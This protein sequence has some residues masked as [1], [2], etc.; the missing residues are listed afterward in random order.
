MISLWVEPFDFP[1]KTFGKYQEDH[2]PDSFS[3][4]ACKPLNEPTTLRFVFGVD[5]RKV[6]RYG[7]LPNYARIPLV[8]AVVADI[9][10]SL[11]A[12]TDLQF[13]DAV[14]E[15][16]DSQ[17]TEYKAFNALRLAECIDHDASKYT[18][19]PDSN[20]IMSFQKLVFKPACLGDAHIAR[21]REFLPHLLVSETLAERLR[22]EKIKGVSLVSPDELYQTRY[23]R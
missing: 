4:R 12:P 17:I 5:G 20:A 11:C 18:L 14:L 1:E 2:S 19:I 9:L 21:D 16:R 15:T 23:R 3:L 8:N 22:R 7:V 6:R 13:L 10:K